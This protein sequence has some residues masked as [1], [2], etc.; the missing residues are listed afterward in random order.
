MILIH[1][2]KDT[3]EVTAYGSIVALANHTGIGKDK[4]YYHFTRKKKTVYEDEIY[5]IKK[6]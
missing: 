5:Y 1:T 6:R 2:N 4:L 3:K